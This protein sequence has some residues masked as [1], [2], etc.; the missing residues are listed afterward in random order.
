MK[1]ISTKKSR[2]NSREYFRK[3][4]EKNRERRNILQREYQSR[5][6]QKHPEKVK[7][8][9][10]KWNEENPEKL[11]EYRRKRR[12]KPEE[13]FYRYRCSAKNRGYE[14][15]LTREDFVLLLTQSC[16]YCGEIDKIGVDR[17]DNNVGYVLQNCVP[18]CKWCNFFKS[19]EGYR[20]FIERCK[21]ITEHISKV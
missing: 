16:H 17:K 13:K 20:E 4:R 9:R 19:R 12:N 5:Y 2:T 14:F 3:W 7:L 18:C 10:K 1:N 8:A 6:R 15:L 11:K 21:K